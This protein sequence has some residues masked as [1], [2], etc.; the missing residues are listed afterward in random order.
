MTKSLGNINKSHMIKGIY[1]MMFIFPAVILIVV[2]VMLG[3]FMGKVESQQHIYF[4]IGIGLALLLVI[5]LLI[6]KNGNMPKYHFVTY[7]NG[8]KVL[9]RKKQ[10]PDA[11]ILFEEISDAWL[12]NF[13]RG[14]Q[15]QYLAFKTANSDYFLVSPKY[16]SND[17]LIQTI[18]SM[19]QQTQAD[20]LATS[21][22]E[23]R[24]VGFKHF[25]NWAEGVILSEK[26]IIPYLKAAKFDEVS[27][28]R[29]SI[30]DGD[31]AYAILD[32]NRVEYH[33][34]TKVHI[35]SKA[36][37]T[38]FKLPYYSMD[39]ADLFIRVVNHLSTTNG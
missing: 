25:A 18:L 2:A 9:Y 17:K 8:I 6:M 32:I 16:S 33:D 37:D 7:D 26:A 23:G 19:Q 28:D 34:D 30:Y 29:F 5:I 21:I 10:K 35:I 36:E 1:S 27:V 24:R 22:T 39:N 14:T 12:F 20:A 13:E 31:R 15:P 4:E 3:V 11:E 38:I